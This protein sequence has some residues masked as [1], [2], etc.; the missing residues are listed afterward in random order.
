MGSGYATGAANAGAVGMFHAPGARVTVPWEMETMCLLVGQ[1]IRQA[2][3]DA[4][5]LFGV[6]ARREV[7]EASGTFVLRQI[8]LRQEA[9]ELVRGWFYGKLR[10]LARAEV[11]WAIRDRQEMLR[12]F[13]CRRSDPDEDSE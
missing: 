10:L 4:H 8:R 12:F 7:G 1:M 2:I 3:K 11:F 9:R 13:C 6:R 5:P